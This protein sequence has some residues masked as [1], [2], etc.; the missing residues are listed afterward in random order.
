MKDL[1]L[2]DLFGFA[3]GK[4]KRSSTQ[5]IQETRKELGVDKPIQNKNTFK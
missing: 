3:K 5:I 1:P 4:V 2:T